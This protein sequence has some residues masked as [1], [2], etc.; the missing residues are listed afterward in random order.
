MGANEPPR[1]DRCALDGRHSTACSSSPV[2]TIVGAVDLLPEQADLLVTLD[3]MYDG[4]ELM[5]TRAM[6]PQGEK[7]QHTE[8]DGYEVV[9][10]GQLLELQDSG[11]IQMRA[12]G[13]PTTHF[14]R[15]TAEGRTAA[16]AHRAAAATRSAP[17]VVP[18]EVRPLALDWADEVYPI[19]DAV[20]RL[21]SASPSHKGVFQ[22][23]INAELGR[24][25]DDERTD[26][27]LMHL[28]QAGWVNKVIGSAA[29]SGPLS[30][31]PAPR[32]LEYLGGWPTDRGDI[33]LGRLIELLEER[34]DATDDA[35]DKSRLQGLLESVKSVG[36][37]VA[38][39]LITEAVLGPVA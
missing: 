4:D 17:P 5:H 31:T 24:A 28:E 3:S 7:I 19:L 33:A 22:Q 36:E 1:P 23:A 32:T 11:M 8:R 10:L 21:Y 9:K 18:V 25:E 16:A 37:S 2:G 39:R 34:I 14:V 29:T 30:C 27:V 12:G 6:G 26:L 35:V 15:L 20:F 38:A 13:S